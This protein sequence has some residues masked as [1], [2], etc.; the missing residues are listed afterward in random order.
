MDMVSIHGLMEES[1]KDTGQKENKTETVYLLTEK[2][3]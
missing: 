3:H 2:N 1:T